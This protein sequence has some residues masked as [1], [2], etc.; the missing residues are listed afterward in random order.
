MRGIYPDNFEIKIGF[1]KIRE[2]LTLRCL[3]PIGK[4]V[5]LAMQF[6]SDYESLKQHHGETDEFCRILREF[7]QFPTNHYYDLRPSLQKIKLEGRFLEVAE[8]FDLKRSLESVRAIVTFFSSQDDQT[9]F[10]LLRKKAGFVKVFPYIYG[11][12]DAILNK[13]G[14]IRDNASPELATIRK[15]ILLMQSSMSKRL[16]SI[17]KKAQIGWTRGRGSIG[18]NTRWK[19][20]NTHCI[21]E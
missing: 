15:N 6:T 9:I 8:L 1:D 7:D 18:F 19:G 17:L 14:Q 20:S 21:I 12:I 16:H 13:N 5:V 10:P 4:E 3:S 11:R 2:M